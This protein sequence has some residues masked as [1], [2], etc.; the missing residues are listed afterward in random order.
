MRKARKHDDP[1][2]RAAWMAEFGQ[3]CA[4]CWVSAGNVQIQCHHMI[5]GERGRPD[6]PANFLALCFHFFDDRPKC[7]MLA[8]G[9]RI[10]HPRHG[11]WPKI[12]KSAQL[13]LKHESDPEHFDARWL[14]ENGMLGLYL[15]E[16]PAMLLE[17]RK[18]WAPMELPN[19]CAKCTIE[20]D[21]RYAE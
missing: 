14:S 8:E 16:P 19:L 18:R 6:H 13:W 9:E 2:L 20:N 12:D 11:H 21:A 1:E 7:H 3:R 4:C 17:Q 15:Y 5:G 10:P